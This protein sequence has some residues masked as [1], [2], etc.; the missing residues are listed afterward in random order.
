MLAQKNPNID[1]AITSMYMLSQDFDIREQMIRR[2]EYFADEKYTQETIAKQKK[3]LAEKD[4]ALVEKDRLIAE[5]QAKLA[6]NSNS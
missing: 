5:L 6:A 1:M 4:K 3:A 2:E